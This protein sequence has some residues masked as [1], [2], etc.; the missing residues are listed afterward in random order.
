MKEEKFNESST[1]NYVTGFRNELGHQE[2]CESEANMKVL[3]RLCSEMK[4]DIKRLEMLL[5]VACLSVGVCALLNLY[6]LFK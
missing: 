5:F 1:G 2:A 3:M 6:T 4:G